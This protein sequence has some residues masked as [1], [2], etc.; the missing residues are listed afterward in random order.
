MTD[1]AARR[2]AQAEVLAGDDRIRERAAIAREELE[3]L[4]ARFCP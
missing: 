1:D 3:R 4:V 2:R